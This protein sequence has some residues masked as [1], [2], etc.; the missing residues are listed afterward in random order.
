M[1]DR[2]MEG[3]FPEGKL[4]L[5]DDRKMMISPKGYRWLEFQKANQTSGKSATD[6]YREFLAREATRSK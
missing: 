1:S 2:P 4:D 6:L 5:R 3:F